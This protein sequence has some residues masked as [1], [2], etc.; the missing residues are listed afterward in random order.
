MEKR[1]WE[2]KDLHEIAMLF[3]SADAAT[4]K[5]VIE[6]VAKHYRKEIG[7]L[8]AEVYLRRASKDDIVKAL[9]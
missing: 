9:S 8:S 3:K 2:G 5:E 7:H 6:Y 1:E 4:Q